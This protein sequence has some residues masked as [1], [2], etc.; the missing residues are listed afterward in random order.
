MKQIK[1]ILICMLLLT[2][3]MFAGC[4]KKDEK[5]YAIDS[6][7]KITD[8]KTRDE[9]LKTIS[10]A[11][12]QE[13]PFVETRI[14]YKIAGDDDASFNLTAKSIID[15]RREAQSLTDV[16][17][18][19][20]ADKIKKE[21]NISSYFI[22]D[23]LYVKLSGE[24][25]ET[26]F[27]KISDPEKLKRTGLMTFPSTSVVN[28]YLENTADAINEKINDLTCGTDAAGS[29]IVQYNDDEGLFRWVFKEGLPVCYLY[30]QNKATAEYVFK[31]T[32]KKIK[33]PNF[34][35]YVNATS[36]EF[37]QKLDSYFDFK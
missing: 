11:V 27:F 12:M 37:N 25:H 13:K 21:I 36:E 10:D 26:S 17:I 34:K 18:K 4:K 22:N 15:T 2:I 7:V 30:R 5:M 3:M 19:L 20:K 16:K 28:G 24:K 9:C 33:K 32:E 29:F 35:K 8:A 23:T 31:Y 14:E 1:S 6:E